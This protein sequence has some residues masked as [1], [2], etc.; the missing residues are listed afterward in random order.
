MAFSPVQALT[1][2]LGQG[3]AAQPAWP[4]TGGNLRGYNKSLKAVKASQFHL[5]REKY[6]LT[7]L[8]VLPWIETTHVERA[9]RNANECQ[10]FSNLFPAHLF[11]FSSFVMVVL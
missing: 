1:K 8:C 5:K 2:T 3:S 4:H 10:K 9:F 7:E 11:F 6:I